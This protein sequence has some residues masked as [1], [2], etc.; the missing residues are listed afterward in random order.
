MIPSLT[1]HD[2]NQEFLFDT[3]M[4]TLCPDASRLANS[5]QVTCRRALPEME[6]HYRLELLSLL[7][8]MLS[9]HA[10][11]CNIRNTHE[12]ADSRPTPMERSVLQ[13]LHNV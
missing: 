3:A 9:A 5:C 1:D 8:A 6:M 11:G 12:M 10:P 4:A 13:P 7:R 2:P